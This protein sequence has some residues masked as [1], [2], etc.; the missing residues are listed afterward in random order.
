M[1][2]KDKRSLILWRIAGFVLSI[3]PLLV[4]VGIS[5]DKLV[6]T[7]EKAVSLGFGAVFAAVFL[8]LKTLDRLPKLK[9]LPAYLVALVV[10]WA[11][12]PLLDDVIIILAA[13]T[14]GE[15]L[16][17]VVAQPKIRRLKRRI[18]V[19]EQADASAK[20]TR[21]AIK[22]LFGGGGNG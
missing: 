17:L 1:M 9:R 14:V 7:P 3:A 22:E 4:Y 19:G 20:A 15:V 12:R 5:A 21:D 10:F 8:I 11:L 18:E 16:D 13:A 6:S 2:K